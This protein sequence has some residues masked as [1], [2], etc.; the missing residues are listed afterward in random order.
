MRC[1][2][3]VRSFA[4]MCANKTVTFYLEESL[5]QSAEAGAHNFIGLMQGVLESGGY[6]VS[7]APAEAAA[8]HGSGRALTHMTQPPPGGLVFRRVYSYPFWAIEASAERWHWDV[9]RA[10]FDPTRIDA[11]AAV[12]FCG[13][14]RKRLF[15]DASVGDDGFIYVPLQG[16]IQKRRSFQRCSPVQMIETVLSAYPGRKVIVGLHPKEHYSDA[17]L[18]VLEGLEQAHP[19]MSVV[20]G[21]METRL[22]RCS[23]VVTQNS[24]VALFG[25]LL[26][27]P[28]V[29]FA[30]IDFHH[31]TLKDAEGLQALGRHKPDYD[32]YMFW[33]WQRMSINAGRDNAADKIS[34]RFR[35]FGW[36]K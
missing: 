9:T 35:R 15:G 29:L 7:F 28:A 2:G 27:K 13:R 4:Y 12:S 32:A 20:T 18:A 31:I 25:Y 33:F 30:E 5:R 21:G 1:C 26:H 36:M 34:A 17:D 8:D 24:S 23:A 6:A 19:Q 16:V 3:A 10:Q 22:P 14:W 11:Q